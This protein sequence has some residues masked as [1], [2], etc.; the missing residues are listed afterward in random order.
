MP[1]EGLYSLMKEQFDGSYPP[2]ILNGLDRFGYKK[3]VFVTKEHFQSSPGGIGPEK[4]T[5][6][7]LA[8]CTLVLSYAK[9]AKDPLQ[10]GSS[11]KIFT[12]FTPRTHF[13]KMLSHVSSKLPAKGDELWA[14][15]NILACYQRGGTK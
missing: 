15:F 3:L 13:N 8:F 2:N 10:P 6:D 7:V 1:L 9:N 5:D 14:L 12:T 4:A 11:P